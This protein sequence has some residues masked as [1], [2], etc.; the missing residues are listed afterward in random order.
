MVQAIDGSLEAYVIQQYTMLRGAAISTTEKTT[1]R[2]GIQQYKPSTV[3]DNQEDLEKRT[4]YIYMNIYIKN[5]QTHT[6]THLSPSTASNFASRV[7]RYF[8]IIY[9]FVIVSQSGEIWQQ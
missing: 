4:L 8:L 3:H 2:Y 1:V 9:F 6:R 5:T 7:N